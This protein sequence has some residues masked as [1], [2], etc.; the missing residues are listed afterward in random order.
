LQIVPK[1]FL[2]YT[3]YRVKK[4]IQQVEINRLS[5]KNYELKT[6]TQERKIRTWQQSQ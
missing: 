2:G 4:A 3:V 1:K 6:T 5:N